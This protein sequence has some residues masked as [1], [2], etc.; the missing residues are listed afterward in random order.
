MGCS[1]W[2]RKESGTT[3]QLT[4]NTYA[5]GYVRM[6]SYSVRLTLWTVANQAPLSMEFSGQEY[7]SELP[8][9]SPGDLPDPGIKPAFPVA[10]GF[11]TTEPPEEHHEIG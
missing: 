4:L 10:G 3:E 5:T 6:L 2:G 9:T 11:F 1:P 8:F 7:L